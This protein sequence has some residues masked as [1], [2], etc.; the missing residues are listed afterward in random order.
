MSCVSIKPRKTS[1]P[2]DDTQSGRVGRVEGT[3]ELVVAGTAYLI[4]YRIKGDDVQL[5]RV[6]HEAQ[7][8]PNKL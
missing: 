7:K 3:R 6:F 1:K 2:L 8:W 4:P 5:L